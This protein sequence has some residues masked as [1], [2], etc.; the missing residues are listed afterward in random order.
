MGESP[1]FS[2][3]SDF[4]SDFFGCSDLIRASLELFAVV[5]VEEELIKLRTYDLE[6]SQAKFREILL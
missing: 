1:I 6:W 2:S 5:G 3:F 4:Q